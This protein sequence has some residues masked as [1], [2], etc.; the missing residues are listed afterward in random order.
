MC[1]VLPKILYSGCSR[2][3]TLILVVIKTIML[4]I[5]KESI[6]PACV[7]VCNID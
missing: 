3:L 4:C 1:V 7:K 5:A 6:A 2:W